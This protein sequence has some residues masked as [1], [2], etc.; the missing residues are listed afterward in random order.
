[1]S[2]VAEE[3]IDNPSDWDHYETVLEYLS[4]TLRK[5]PGD[6]FAILNSPSVCSITDLEMMNSI[7][8][9]PNRVNRRAAQ[10]VGTESPLSREEIIAALHGLVECGSVIDLGDGMYKEAG[11]TVDAAKYNDYCIVCNRRIDAPGDSMKVRQLSGH[12]RIHKGCRDAH[13]ESQ[14]D[15]SG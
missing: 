3:I 14:Q 8:T 5:L 2:Y 7:R 12:R 15:W 4:M 6:K 1:M 13:L 10:G 9:S 11:M